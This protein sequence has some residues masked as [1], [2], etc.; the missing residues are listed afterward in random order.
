MQS[1]YIMASY[2]QNKQDN[3][4]IKK[5]PSFQKAA[6]KIRTLSSYPRLNELLLYYSKTIEAT[7]RDYLV[8]K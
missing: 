7:K 2:M 1:F 3:R 6:S 5:R 8:E 4:L